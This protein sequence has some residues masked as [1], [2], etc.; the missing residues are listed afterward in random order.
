MNAEVRDLEEIPAARMALPIYRIGAWLLDGLVLLVPTMIVMLGVG[1]PTL[2][3][4]TL[5]LR[6]EVAVLTAIFGLRSV[7]ELVC[8][9]LR[10][11]TVGKR[12]CK[13]QVLRMDD[14]SLP[15]WGVALTRVIAQNI[16]NLLAV[17]VG[18]IGGL[19]QLADFLFVLRAPLH[20]AL[21]DMAA[22]TVVIDLRP[23]P[24]R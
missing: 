19:Y 18:P 14:G 3:G 16:A 10:G 23:A 1:R 15:G 11:Q 17:V 4:N 7:Y 5:V 13:I 12:V 20:Q 21:H 9:A 24:P 8:T 6:H 22:R 2:D